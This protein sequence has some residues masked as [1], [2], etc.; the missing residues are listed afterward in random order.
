MTE[1]VNDNSIWPVDQKHPVLALSIAKLPTYSYVG[2]LCYFIVFHIDGYTIDFILVCKRAH[3][4][5]LKGSN[6]LV[7]CLSLEDVLFD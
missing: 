1:L 3:K 4:A 7:F 6:F 2:I 5:P